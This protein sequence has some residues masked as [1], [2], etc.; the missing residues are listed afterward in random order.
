M[1]LIKTAMQQSATD[2]TTGEI[3][4]NI[5][6]TGVAST[7]QQRV[8]TITEYI[9]NTMVSLS[10]QLLKLTRFLLQN[11]FSD[12]I[13]KS[14]IKYHNLLEFLNSHAEKGDLEGGQVYEHEMKDALS[15]LEEDGFLNC[16]GHKKAPTIRFCAE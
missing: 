5:I 8:K 4:M 7:S 9:K 16:I 14:G 11:Q 13:A 1:R 15:A 10:N 2:P 12:R 3:D 6:T